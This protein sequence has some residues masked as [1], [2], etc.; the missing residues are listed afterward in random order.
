MVIRTSMLP[1]GLA[2]AGLLAAA[3]VAHAAE[4]R[5]A[6]PPGAASYKDHVVPVLARY[7]YSCHGAE[8]QKADLNL[9]AYG[10]EAAVVKDRDRWENVQFFLE[11]GDM[12]PPG[13][14][15]RPTEAEVALVSGWIQA[16]LAQVDCSIVNPGHVT[17]R[18]LNRSEYNN[19]IRDLVGIDFEPA[20][21]FP[22]DN[23][24]YGF[25]NIGDVL[26]LDPLLVEKY[27]QA[28][29]EITR[30]PSTPKAPPAG[31]SSAST[32]GPSS[33]GGERHEDGRLLASNGELVIE[34]DFPEAGHYILMARAYGEQ[35]G[36]IR[37]RMA[38]KIDGKTVEEVDVRA[39]RDAGTTRPPRR[40]RPASTGS[41]SPSSTT[42]PTTMR[43]TR[44]SAATAT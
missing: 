20:K 27:L 9:A 13:H 34:H 26:S 42:T 29:E 1:T 33:A 38:F 44:S 4:D 18:R 24:G 37:S 22:A 39:E 11:D 2:L 7:C 17:L 15:P 21:D 14:D 31:R 5:A 25:D 8:K 36:P 12:P 35:A 43:R 28:A 30:P 41:P 6:T 23:V 3:A 19:T 32:A 40:S 16:R 10:D